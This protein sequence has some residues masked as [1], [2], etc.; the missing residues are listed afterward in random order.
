LHRYAVGHWYTHFERSEK[1]GNS[2]STTDIRQTCIAISE[3]HAQILK[4][5]GLPPLDHSSQTSSK[6]Q[7]GI[8]KDLQVFDN[9][10]DE[11]L[12]G[13]QDDGDHK[14]TGQ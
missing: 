8:I 4:R 13:E 10:K 1:D 9:L 5:K 7:I 11:A 6:L 3:R 14:S 12:H 2:C